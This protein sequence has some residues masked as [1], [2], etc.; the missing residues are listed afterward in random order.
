MIKRLKGAVKYSILRSE[1]SEKDVFKKGEVRIVRYHCTQVDN[2]ILTKQT[3]PTNLGKISEPCCISAP[4]ENHKVL[5]KVKAFVTEISF[6]DASARHSYGLQRPTKKSTRLTPVNARVTHTHTIES[7][8][9]MKENTP[10]FC[11]SGFLIMMLMPIFMNGFVKS[12]TLC[13]ARVIVKEAKAKS[14]FCNIQS[15]SI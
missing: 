12:T 6:L 11:L 3:L 7:R 1:E 5:D 9:F 10:G 14:A 4:K 8:G 13:L 2:L 15:D